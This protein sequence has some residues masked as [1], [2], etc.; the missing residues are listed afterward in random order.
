[1]KNVCLGYSHD[2]IYEHECNN[3]NY[4]SNPTEG[5]ISAGEFIVI[6]NNPAYEAEVSMIIS[7]ASNMTNGSYFAGMFSYCSSEVLE[8]TMD[9]VKDML[10]SRDSYWN[11]NHELLRNLPPLNRLIESMSKNISDASSS[12]VSN[13]VR[14]EFVRAVLLDKMLDA[15]DSALSLEATLRRLLIGILPPDNSD[16]SDITSNYHPS[17]STGVTIS[18]GSGLSPYSESVARK[19]L[20]SLGQDPKDRESV[21]ITEESR[22]EKA[23]A[24]TSKAAATVKA[25]ADAIVA[26]ATAARNA[27]SAAI[28]AANASVE[29]AAAANNDDA[30]IA[31]AAAAEAAAAASGAA[32]NASRAAA[33]ASK[34]AATAAIEAAASKGAA[35]AASRAAAKRNNNS[36]GK[37]LHSGEKGKN[38]IKKPTTKKPQY[39]YT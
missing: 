26:A 29:A 33:I 38:T 19:I 3:G 6:N 1:M 8:I 22:T 16:T 13:I 11:R 35:V 17:T 20:A 12:V 28:E 27:A 24:A 4:K 14:A 7:T 18:S 37:R 32:N 10:K 31:A 9:R 21:K 2:L 39:T 36:L 23:A 25:A 34:I 15:A 30:I 5:K